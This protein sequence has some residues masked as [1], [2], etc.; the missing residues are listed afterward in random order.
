MKQQKK[1]SLILAGVL[2]VGMASLSYG[3]GRTEKIFARNCTEIFEFLE[4]YKNHGENQG[5][6]FKKLGLILSEDCRYI[7]EIRGKRLRIF[8]VQ[9]L[10]LASFNWRPQG[11]YTY[12]CDSIDGKYAFVKEGAVLSVAGSDSTKLI[13][14][15]NF[16][17]ETMGNLL[18]SLT[19]LFFTQEN[20]N[21]GYDES[22]RRKRDSIEN[23]SRN[24][25]AISRDNWDIVDDLPEGG[26]TENTFAFNCMKIKEFLKWYKSQGEHNGRSFKNLGLT[27]SEDC[28]YIVEKRRERWRIFSVKKEIYLTRG[29]ILTSFLKEDWRIKKRTFY[30]DSRDGKYAAIKTGSNLLVAPSNSSEVIATFD[31]Q[32]RK[33]AG[34][35][36]GFITK[37][38]FPVLVKNHESRRREKKEKKRIEKRCI[39]RN[40]NASAN[41]RRS[42]FLVEIESNNG[43]PDMCIIQ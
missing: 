12:R 11:K 3:Q 7:A 24:K 40:S 37:R 43:C 27:L 26:K 39:R 34:F 36:R 9:Q 8:S 6:D 30:C 38:L 35:L 5:R 2:F 25:R 16:D 4:W 28:K 23:S 32:N 33:M 19:S 41:R 14:T 21:Y 29:F 18:K 15:F 31:F 42:E 1:Y 10:L 13:A 20:H 22:K 17:D